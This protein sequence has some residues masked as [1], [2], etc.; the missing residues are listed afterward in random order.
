VRPRVNLPRLPTD[1]WK[2]ATNFKRLTG[3]SGIVCTVKNKDVIYKVGGI[4]QKNSE[5]SGF[6]LPCVDTL[7]PHRLT[8]K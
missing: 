1:S 6:Q 3:L 8:D 4:L 2:H 7:V 5:V